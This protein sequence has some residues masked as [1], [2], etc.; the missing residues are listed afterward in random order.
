MDTIPIGGSVANCAT[1]EEGSANAALG[2]DEER[3][4]LEA[5]QDC[6]NRL[7]EALPDVLENWAGIDDAGRDLLPDR[8]AFVSRYYRL[9]A[10]LALAHMALV[11][12]LA[13]RF[14]HRGV[15]YSDLL[16]EG[17]CG[18]LEAID[19][20]DLRFGSRLST[21][22]TW[23]IRQA[24]QEA[25]ATGAYPVRLSPRHLRQLAQERRC[26]A[27]GDRSAANPDPASTET[28]RF[29]EVATRPRISLD[30]PHGL[31]SR[32]G[33]DDPTDDEAKDAIE[34]LLRSLLPREREVL[35]LRFGLDGR[36]ELSLTQAGAILN[37]SRERVRQI[38]DHALQ[39]LRSAAARG[40]R[41]E[42]Q[43]ACC[44]A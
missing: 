22:A 10:R 16:Q 25:V 30:A 31:A 39:K 18:L 40:R 21:Y 9:R 8:D 2:S 26:L 28:L 7:G 17:F 35:A 15:A 44:H 37:I 23:W 12:H 41:S 3:R 20:F 36:S 43:L 14:C 13:R 29:L 27:T 42:E 4:L 19:R 6:R 33:M 1:P 32:L 11:A 24:L 34:I 38:Q 5:L